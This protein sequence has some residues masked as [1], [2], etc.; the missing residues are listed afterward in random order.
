MNL[1][2]HVFLTIHPFNAEW[3]IP[4]LYWIDLTRLHG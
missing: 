2:K 3:T 1:S 4:S